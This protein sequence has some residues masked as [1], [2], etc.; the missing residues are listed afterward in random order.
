[1]NYVGLLIW[2]F[3]LVYGFVC[4]FNNVPVNSVVYM[5][6]VVVCIMHYIASII[7]DM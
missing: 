2:I 4:I 7:E 5:C 6:A 1:M 3:Q